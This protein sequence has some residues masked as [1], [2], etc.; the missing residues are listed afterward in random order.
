ME[1][2]QVRY[3]LA[4]IRAGSFTAAAEACGV[5]QPGL[6][7][8]IRTLEKELGGVL[9][10]REGNRLVLS[11]LGRTMAPIFE[12]LQE[13]ARE[14]RRV[15]ESYV[16]LEKSSVRL[17]V[18]STVGGR[19]I[20]S[21]LAVLRRKH[22]GIDIEIH[23]AR[24]DDVVAQLDNGDFDLAIMNATQPVRD[25]HEPRG[26]YSERY[27]AAFPRGHRFESLRCVRLADLAGEA[28][29]DRLSCELR[30]QFVELCGERQVKL[31]PG[32]RSDREDWTQE[33]IASGFGCAILPENSVRHP[34]IVTRP[35]EDPEVIR[36]IVVVRVRGRRLSQAAST[37]L[38]M[39]QER[40]SG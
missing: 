11:D 2:S 29:V 30:K 26:L 9:F 8:S 31:L 12:R 5:S 20:A 15:A 35:F 19:Y 10:H 18:L 16:A 24:K 39:L 7:K 37:V 34:E 40:N 33:L 36:E 4:A 6:T 28:F 14:A 32:A 27:I 1:L 23:R 25:R 3:A 38:D 21:R 17:G 22:P 13:Q